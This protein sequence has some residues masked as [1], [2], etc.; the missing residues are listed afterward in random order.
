MKL[1]TFIL[2][3]KVEK[4]FKKGL[5]IE[6]SAIPNLKCDEVFTQRLPKKLEDFA[7]RRQFKHN[8]TVMYPFLPILTLI[9]TVR[10]ENCTIKKFRT[11]DLS[12]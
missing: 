11:A 6:S 10:A 4:K 1:K 9:K 2:L 7:Q 8:T 12:L 5:C 3:Q